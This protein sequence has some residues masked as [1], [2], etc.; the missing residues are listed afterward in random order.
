MPSLREDTQ[1]MIPKDGWER[2]YHLHFC[3]AIL[4]CEIHNGKLVGGK[5]SNIQKK[6]VIIIE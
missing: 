5:K 2:K 6:T 1:G 3:N 4:N